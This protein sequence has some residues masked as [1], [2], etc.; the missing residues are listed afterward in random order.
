MLKR[1][2]PPGWPPHKGSYAVNDPRAPVAICVLGSDPLAAQTAGI[3]GVAIAGSL[4]TANVGI[5]A[6]VLNTISN[7]NLRFMVVCG[8][9]SKLFR[10]G[11]SLVAL[12]DNGVDEE[13]LILGAEGHEPQLAALSPAAV[14]RYR[15]QLTLIDLREEQDAD[16]I[17]TAVA[18]AVELD[19]GPL[20]EDFAS[21]AAAPTQKIQP[22]GHRQPL[23]YDPK[24]FFVITADRD[25][26]E[27]SVVHYGPDRLP[28]HEMRG[29]SAEPM[30]LGLLRE[31]LVTQLSHAG[32]LGAELAKAE[33][34]LRLNLEYTQ[35]RPLPKSG[36]ATL[37]SE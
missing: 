16:A 30:L 10:Q 23:A 15:D 22:G 3:D 37:S 27:I 4:H 24:G 35:D 31:R 11:Q 5:E 20:A 21:A 29:R 9:D 12:H 6:I 17:A 25:E 26:R 36:S 33:T 7:R 28:A 1:A 13:R 18:R 14:E 19:P 32:Y 8:K 2:T 34:A